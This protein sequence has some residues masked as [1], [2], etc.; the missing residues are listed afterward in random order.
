MGSLNIPDKI[1]QAKKIKKMIR[2]KC[3]LG[4]ASGEYNMETGGDEGGRVSHNSV[5]TDAFN[6]SDRSSGVDVTP[7]TGPSTVSQ[8]PRSHNNHLSY[9][10]RLVMHHI[11][12]VG[13]S[14]MP[15][16]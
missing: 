10:L 3:T 16:P 4:T 5:L 14:P 13:R 11:V 8:L 7:L 15:S 9:L 1:K 12:V 6:A 2:D